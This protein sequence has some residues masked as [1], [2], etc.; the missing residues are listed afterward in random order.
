MLSKTYNNI[1]KRDFTLAFFRLF[2]TLQNEK[3]LT[4]SEIRILTEYILLKG[5]ENSN[6]FKKDNTDKVVENLKTYY[7]WSTNPNSLK[8]TMS[9]SLKRKGFIVVDSDRIKYVN[10]VIMK[11]LNKAYSSGNMEFNFNFKF[12]IKDDE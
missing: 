4:E 6:R 10:P 7:D 2:N 1:T 5:I 12:E 3:R 8:V 11:Y 9:T